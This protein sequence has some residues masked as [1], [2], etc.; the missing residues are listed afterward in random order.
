MATLVVVNKRKDFEAEIPGV[1]VVTAKEYLTHKEYTGMR[2]SRVFNLCRSYSYQ[3]T[4]Y[5]ISL[6]AAARG[7]K[8]MPSIATIQDTK[9]QAIIR[10]K[11]EEL[12]DLIQKSLASAD[13]SE[14]EL[15]IF[16]GKS[17]NAKFAALAL[18]I[19]YQFEAPFLRAYFSRKGDAWRLDD[20]DPVSTKN[21]PEDAKEFALR[22]AADFFNTKRAV[23]RKQPFYRYEMAILVNPDEEQPPSDK[24]AIKKFLKAASELGIGAWTITKEDFNRIAEYDALFIRETTNVNHYT[25]R[26]ARRAAIEGLVV[27]DDPESILRCSNKVYL[28]ELLESNNIPKP[29]T[30]VIHKDNVDDIPNQFS[31]PVILKLPDS[32]FSQGVI[33]VKTRDELEEKAK[34]MFAKSDLF[35]AQEYLPTEFDW[36]IGILD[37]KPLF[38]CKY[39]MAGKHWQIM[40]WAKK[41]SDR[42]GRHKTVA[43]HDAP[44]EVVSTALKAANLIGNGFYG[45]DLKEIDAKPYVIE[46]NDNPSIDSGVEDQ[47]MKDELYTSIMRVFLERMEKITAG[48]KG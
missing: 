26:F 10:L 7:H 44:N 30:L 5:Y 28:A 35:I 2:G 33:K 3:S 18:Q 17:Q 1:Q 41:G 24:T 37:R 6:L 36:R 16:F 47:V 27:L 23:N 46:V 48:E 29:R 4:G 38:A 45:V 31:F 43:I 19:F 8:V 39:Y 22:S 20:V 32:C 12:N 25:Y 13:A 21:L 14:Y 42:F 15:D 34:E 40:N 9:T 11:S